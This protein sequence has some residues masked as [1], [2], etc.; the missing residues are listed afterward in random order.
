MY[1][2]CNPL[3]NIT[4]DYIRHGG[5]VI[6]HIFITYSLSIIYPI[7]MYFSTKGEIVDLLSKILTP[8]VLLGILDLMKCCTKCYTQYQELKLLVTSGKE[9]VAVTKNGISYEDQ[10]S[11]ND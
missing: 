4:A 1:T 7:V 6:M 11:R 3:T 2:L 10:T 9:R 8:A 5:I